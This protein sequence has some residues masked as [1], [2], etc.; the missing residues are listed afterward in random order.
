M[1]IGQQG[2][3]VEVCTA[4]FFSGATAQRCAGD[5]F[6]HCDQFDFVGKSFKRTFHEGDRGA[7]C[8][9]IRADCY[10]FTT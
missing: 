7:V 4:M 6:A 10:F 3:D 1:A 9:L 2:N 8:R 5:D